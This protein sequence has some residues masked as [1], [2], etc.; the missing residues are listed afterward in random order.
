MRILVIEDDAGI[1]QGLQINLQRRGYTVDC[2][3]RLALAWTALTVEHFDAVL[4]DLGL[5]DGDG[6]ALLHKIRERRSTPAL[7][8]QRPDPLLPVLILTAR[9]H[10]QE[11]I[12]GLNSG[13]DDYLTKPFDIDELEARL[14]AMLRRSAGRASSTIYYGD[15]EIHPQHHTVTLAGQPISI[16]AREFAL[17]LLLVEARGRVLSRQHIEERLY[18]WQSTIESN[19]VEVHIHHLRRKIGS[20]RIQTMRGVGYFMPYEPS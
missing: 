14:R 18:N 2:A 1:A 15:L 13:A 19:T 12:A 17:L 8:V 20:D 5:P 9:D 16:A 6:S 3:D 11:R 4:L 10:V 7:T